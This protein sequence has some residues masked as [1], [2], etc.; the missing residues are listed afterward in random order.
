[1]PI[2]NNPLFDVN[3]Y[4]ELREER[5]KKEKKER[6]EKRM[7]WIPTTERLPEDKQKLVALNKKR[8]MILMQY[9]HLLLSTLFHKDFTH[10]YPLPEPPN[11]LNNEN[12]TQPSSNLQETHEIS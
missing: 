10:W 3:L 12:E 11:E 6:S 9:S 2:P 4:D 5:M 1:M 7:E 8:G